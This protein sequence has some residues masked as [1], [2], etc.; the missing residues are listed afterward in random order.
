MNEDWKNKLSPWDREMLKMVESI[1]GKPCEPKNGGDHFFFEADYE[2]HKDKP[3][4]LLALWDAIEGRGGKRIIGMDDDPERN[5]FIV[6]V[7]FSNE[8]YPAL[9]RCDRDE[10][11]HPEAGTPYYSI[12]DD[13]NEILAVQV[14]RGNAAQLLAFV[15]NGEMRIDRT[16][17]GKSVFQFKN[18]GAS[19]VWGWQS[20]A[21]VE[22]T[23]NNGSETFSTT[24][25]CHRDCYFCFNYNVA[26]YEKFV[27]EGCPWREGLDFRCGP[28]SFPEVLSAAP[29]L[30]SGQSPGF[31]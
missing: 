27:R 28:S 5:V 20:K 21:C 15:G 8:R 14:E 19:I 26:D 25:K 9:I 29:E 24:F 23:G 18:A 16:P 31:R 17:G 2:K 3:E 13:A 12:V 10:T 6:T 11:E 7:L 30:C 22:C 4:Y 1:T